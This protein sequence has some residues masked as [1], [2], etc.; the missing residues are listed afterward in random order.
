M[1]DNT[2]AQK[3]GSQVSHKDGLGSDHIEDV[4]RGQAH[5]Q[6]IIVTKEDNKTILRKIDKAIL[7]VLVWV[8]FLQV[9]DKSVLGYSAV[10]GL[11]KDT[12]LVGSQYSLVG[13]MAPIAQLAWL[14]FSTFLIVKVPNRTLMASLVFGWGI[15]L[16]SM[17]ACHD[18]AGLATTRFFLGLFE[19][20]CLPLFSIITSQWYRRA[21]Q[22]LRVAIWYCMNG[23]ATIIGSA[24]SYGL[25][26]I[27]SPAL[28]PWQIIFLFVGLV[29]IV[30]AP[31]VYLRLENNI[32]TARFLT[33]RQ[34][35]QA[36]ER[37]RANQTGLGS[38][39][40]KWD[41]VLE[42]LLDPKTYVWFS[43][44]LL[45]NTG[46]AVA[47][48]FG[49]LILNGLGFNP[50][51]TLLLNM[52][53]GAVQ[54]LIIIITSYIVQRSP[55]KSVI[56]AILILPVIAGLAILYRV[57]RGHSHQGVLLL[58]YYF[59]AFLY[60]ANPLL[61]SWIL[62]NTAGQTKK[63]LVMCVFNIGVSAGNLVG[64]QL[65]TSKD[66]PAYL[67]GLRAVLGIFVALLVLVFIQLAYLVFLNKMQVQKRRANGKQEIIQDRSMMIR[68]AE[69]D[70]NMES[71]HVLL[72]PEDADITDRKNDEF[73]YIY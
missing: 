52:P 5:Q 23:M 8:Y 10:F 13:S 40:F 26:Q 21:E 46:A 65:F 43:M 63:S 62:G 31:I 49:P 59:L 69:N 1:N 67:P 73:V 70:K 25:A 44:A 4:Q 42:G 60:G 39:K 7:P 2:P 16:A 18:F 57:P 35:A 68:Y 20:A 41:H 11:Q 12:G 29:T 30:T 51:I 6:G 24:L 15:A 55:M 9:L 56:T 71:E 72:N 58:G 54:V 27:S 22:P 36:T 3:D 45:L 14:P 33:E 37:L 19:A 38:E 17:A 64:P 66:A 34:R 32:D 47:N 61:V 48:I 50:N 28:K 53:F